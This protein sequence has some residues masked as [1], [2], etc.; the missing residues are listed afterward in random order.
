M[1]FFGATE[2]KLSPLFGEREDLCNSVA[3]KFAT[4]ISSLI[5]DWIEVSTQILIVDHSTP[6]P[7][8]KSR[9]LKPRIHVNDI[10]LWSSLCVKNSLE[11]VLNF[12]TGDQ[13]DIEFVKSDT[14]GI[15]VRL[16]MPMSENSF[17]SI[18][19]LSEGLDSI[20]GIWHQLEDNK[21]SYLA[22]TNI[23]QNE[24]NHLLRNII[25]HSDLP[26]SFRDRITS[27]K[28]SLQRPRALRNLHGYEDKWNRG[29]GFV[30]LNNAAILAFLSNLS[31]VEIY[32][33][34]IESLNFPLKRTSGIGNSK[35][36]HPITLYRMS[37]FVCNLTKRKIDFKLPFLFNTKYE[38]IAKSKNM[39]PESIIKST[40]SCIHFSARRK[41]PQC[42]HCSGCILRQ[43]SLYKLGIIDENNYDRSVW[44]MSLSNDKYSHDIFVNLVLM[45]SLRKHL[46]EGDLMSLSGLSL[47]EQ[48]EL[49]VA[50]AW[51][52]GTSPSEVD[53]RIKSLYARYLHEWDGIRE[54]I[55]ILKDID[56]NIGIRNGE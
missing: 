7:S 1:N 34:G 47:R 49:R 44:E 19:L 38:I 36:M 13:W 2:Y 14:Q 27:V 18:C 37:M 43:Q 52:S 24:R 33:N 15:P 54:Q 50:A 30:Y 6:R 45:A 55:P 56:E 11:S 3:S 51:V 20:A 35:L 32:E 25:K 4:E 10:D 46:E 5:N 8:K 53:N 40:I 12:S 9:V 42:G 28:I 31:E 17:T 22:V 29:R 21:S 39:L 48:K 26:E 16:S 41:N 23:V